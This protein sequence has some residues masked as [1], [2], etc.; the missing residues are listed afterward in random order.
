MMV[1]HQVLH[2]RPEAFAVTQSS[3]RLPVAK[4]VK[5]RF[6]RRRNQITTPGA[7]PT[8]SYTLYWRE[9]G[10]KKFQSLGPHANRA[11]AE[12]MAR[13]KEAEL[14]SPQRLD[15]LKPASWKDFVKAYRDETYPGH[16][17]PP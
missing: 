6:R 8:L 1:L 14:N 2:L 16:D 4:Y 9:F 7:E 12:R 10:R 3:S 11:F 13:Q 15:S 17:L 5:V